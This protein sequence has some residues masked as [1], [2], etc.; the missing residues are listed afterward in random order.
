MKI[1]TKILFL[2]VAVIAF[3]SCA[4]VISTKEC[5]EGHQVLG[6]WYGLWHGMIVPFAFIGSLF[7]NSVAVYAV[8]NNGAMYNFGFVWGIYS[9]FSSTRRTVTRTRTKYINLKRSL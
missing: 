9:S 2:L 7:D 6:F 8:N 5:V 4:D 1:S 3:T